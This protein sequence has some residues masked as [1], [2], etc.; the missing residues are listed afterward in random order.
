MIVLHLIDAGAGE[1]GVLACAAAVTPPVATPPPT[2]DIDHRVLVI[3][4]A[5]VEARARELGLSVDARA[6]TGGMSALSRART[7]RAAVSQLRVRVDAVQAW[8]LSAGAIADRAGWGQR[9]V[10]CGSTP[11]EPVEWLRGP[12]VAMWPWQSRD[13]W[14]SA[15]AV[16][17]R[18]LPMPHLQSPW[19]VPHSARPDACYARTRVELGLEPADEVVAL[20]A[21]P[22]D[23]GDARR[24]VYLL[25]LLHV[26]GRR[27]VGL[28]PEGCS[29]LDRA[30]RY[31]R[32]HGRRWGLI[33]VRGPLTRAL[34]AA[35]VAA[36]DHARGDAAG[37]L[38]L[39][40]ES[41]GLS[42]VH[43][44]PGPAAPEV[45]RKTAAK[46]IEVLDRRHERTHRA[47][48]RAHAPHADPLFASTIAEI[49]RDAASALHATGV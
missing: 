3:G 41:S 7:V 38:G 34:A 15:G 22:P 5:W 29:T 16:D 39:V 6:A 33:P 40:A 20:L 46:A 10:V 49:W 21:D 35:D 28:V 31:T 27:I 12:T 17:I 11:R 26:G 37:L 24:F 23:D 8:S 4:P 19:D 14:R 2:T 30:A 32:A 42:V 9:L 48:A 44:G 47:P 36:I 45:A 1:G 43:I 18:E 13:A 25:G